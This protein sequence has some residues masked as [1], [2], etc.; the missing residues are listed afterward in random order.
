MNRASL[1]TVH[2]RLALAFAPLLL[3]QGLTGASLLFCGPVAQAIDP[4]GMTALGAG[5]TASTSTLA[6]SAET[7]FSG[8]RTRRMFFPA[9][10]GDTV[11][12]ELA[13]TNRPARYASLDPGSGRVL[14]AGPIW[15]FPLEAALQL[16]YGLMSGRL[17]L[18]V[19]LAN[20]IVL[21]LLAASGLGYWWPGRRRALKALAIPKASPKRLKLRL[22]HRSC[23]VTLSI[24]LL[25]SATTGILLV[26]PD[27]AAAPGPASVPAPTPRS[28]EQVEYAVALA[29]RQFP[30]ARLHDIR[31]PPADKIDV[32]FFAPERNSRA[33][34]IVS[35]AV[36]R[37]EIIKSVPAE[38]NPVQWMK[39]LPLHSGGSFGVAGRLV[40]LIEGLVLAF[41][42]I[43]GPTVWWRA[44]RVKQ[45][46]R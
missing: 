24:L 25:F 32:S 27:L 16:H 2:R 46:R 33:V 12:V 7:A 9:S 39:V 30:A 22:W 19:I 1:L 10:R 29:S 17:G 14:A 26:V 45:G 36:S 23:G 41:L 34:H 38:Q 11:L 44:R 42:A 37:G 35:V 5:P 13:G 43:S 4:A 3:L 28:P 18:F 6:A 15:R 8:Y 20:A 21:S 40:L 31:F